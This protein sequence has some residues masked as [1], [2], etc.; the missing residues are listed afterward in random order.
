MRLNWNR[1]FRF[2]KFGLLFLILSSCST[3]NESFLVGTYTDAA[4]QGFH[5]IE[6][7]EKTNQIQSD[8]TIETDKNPSFII[9]NKAK[10]VIAVISETAS[11]TG[12]KITTFSYNKKTKI[13]TKINSQP[14]LGNNPCS[15]AFSPNEEFLVVANYS[16]G[17]IS[18]FPI[19]KNGVLSEASQEKSYT[20]IGVNKARQEKSHMH[21]VVFHPTE[22][23]VFITDLGGDVIQQIPFDESIVKPLLFQKSV[24]NKLPDGVGPRH[25]V[26]SKNG[27]IAYATLE[28]ANQLGVFSFE[29]GKLQLLKRINLT[30]EEVVLDG[31][32][33]EIRLSNDEQFLYT[34]I[35]GD[36]NLLVAFSLLDEKNPKEIQ[37]ISTQI[38]PRN[39][40]ITKTGNYV[41][42]GNQVSNTIISFKRDY[43]TGLLKETDLVFSVNKPS[44]FFSF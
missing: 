35:R 39:F 6:F 19:D 37:R 8:R 25:L 26:F 36:F 5:T 7:D 20:K 13:V 38:K 40:I 2:L 1:L 41:L 16:G 32:A 15:I 42:V 3:F 11:K 23:F 33:A 27:K 43:K 9:A 10:N 22:K 34:S 14:T 29:D 28:L 12:G 21:C 31:S 30:N 44:Y 4:K 18:V 24:E 17:N